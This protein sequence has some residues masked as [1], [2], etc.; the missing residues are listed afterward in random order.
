[1]KLMT[2][3]EFKPRERFL[4]CISQSSKHEHYIYQLFPLCS[5]SK[6]VNH[7]WLANILTEHR[8]NEEK[9]YEGLACIKLI[10]RGTLFQ[11]TAISYSSKAVGNNL[12]AFLSNGTLA[13]IKLNGIPCHK[14]ILASKSNRL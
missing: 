2:E 7:T 9:N 12:K 5:R 11:N 8:R 13:D 6:V 4:E 3:S 14:V 1:M 10:V